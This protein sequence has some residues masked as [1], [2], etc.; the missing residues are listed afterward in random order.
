[1]AAAVSPAFD[2]ET[3]EA[4]IISFPNSGRHYPKNVRID[5][6]SLRAMK[7]SDDE[8]IKLSTENFVNRFNE[9]AATYDIEPLTVAETIGKSVYSAVLVS[10]YKSSGGDPEYAFGIFQNQIE[11]IVQ[12]LVA[13]L[14]DPR[15]IALL[16][17]TQYGKT[18]ILCGAIILFNLYQSKRSEKTFVRLV[19]PNFLGVE[20][21][22]LNDLD[23]FNALLSGVM[24]DDVTSYEAN[25]VYFNQTERLSRK[26]N[27][28]KNILREKNIIQTLADGYDPILNQFGYTSLIVFIDEADEALSGSSFMNEMM[29]AAKEAAIPTRYLFCSATAWEYKNLQSFL[30]IE[31]PVNDDYAGFL[32]GRQIPVCDFQ[33]LAEIINEPELAKFSISRDYTKTGMVRKLIDAFI[34]GVNPATQTSVRDFD[35][36]GKKGAQWIDRAVTAGEIGFNGRPFNGGS[37]MAIRYGK[38]NITQLGYLHGK[39][40]RSLARMGVSFLCYVGGNAGVTLTVYAPGHPDADENYVEVLIPASRC[41]TICELL[42]AAE[43][44]FD[45]YRDYHNKITFHAVIGVVAL[46]RRA[47]RLPKECNVFLEMSE[48]PTTMTSLEQGSL[49]RLTGWGKFTDT[50]TPMCVMSGD[51][52][53]VVAKARYWFEFHG[54][55]M[56]IAVITPSQYSR[57]TFQE[58]SLRIAVTVGLSGKE[59]ETYS[60]ALKASLK[61]IAR[62]IEGQTEY[63]PTK[64]A[65]GSL[66][67]V[68]KVWKKGDNAVDKDGIVAEGWD[69]DG[70]GYIRRSI[71]TARD[72]K[73]NVTKTKAWT[74]FDIFGML[75]EAGVLELEGRFSDEFGEPVTFLRPGS[76]REDGRV[77]ASEGTYIH[78][79][80]R[81]YE[82]DVILGE[83][84]FGAMGQRDLRDPTIKNNGWGENIIDASAI[85]S[86]ASKKL[87]KLVFI[88]ARD[89]LNHH[90]MDAEA[91]DFTYCKK[92]TAPYKFLASDEDRKF[93]DKQTKITSKS[94]VA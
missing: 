17:E 93:I 88:L 46:A 34:K 71:P 68:K 85:M 7:R 39:C 4:E 87:A 63:A 67:P 81:S 11:I 43:I 8:I 28:K 30:V 91:V 70:D 65:N 36:Y 38:N 25:A 40:K 15:N 44:E 72:D 86:T 3:H 69:F 80:Y 47:M 29:K 53:K 56:K 62:V 57:K 19:N 90:G 59:Y 12:V 2:A 54:M 73:G 41:Q 9:V 13:M 26:A 31:A 84:K 1:M 20:R 77:Y 76:F 92:G 6:V 14:K 32:R 66:S 82:K 89:S 18:G 51:V 48:T 61:R 42:E 35:P 58:P 75:G 49:G 16:A 94:K 24:L 78:V 33:T 79:A 37:H 27:T 50:I 52:T 23:Q 55:T 60:P 22:T 45:K 5:M 10:R 21:Q 74:L 83:G 64:G